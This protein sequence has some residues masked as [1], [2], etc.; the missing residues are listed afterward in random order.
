MGEYEGRVRLVIKHAP[1]PYRDYAKL[2]A[3]ASLAA[4]AQGAFW[5]MHDRLLENYRK[6]DPK[7]L[8]GYAKDLGLDAARF[9]QD[10]DSGRFAARVEEDARLA[11]SLDVYQTPTF[12]INGRVVVGDRPIEHLRKV[13]DEELAAARGRP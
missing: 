5:P 11:R 12:V 9:Q 4:A 10:L 8:V 1:Y 13:V 2:A 6:L 3:Q 7:S